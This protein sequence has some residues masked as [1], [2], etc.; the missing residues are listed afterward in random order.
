MLPCVLAL[1]FSGRADTSSVNIIKATRTKDWSLD[2]GRFSQRCIEINQNHREMY[3]EDEHLEYSLLLA[4]RVS[5]NQ[6]KVI[7]SPYDEKPIR[8]RV[9]C[10]ATMTRS[11]LFD[12][13]DTEK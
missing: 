5:R 8:K 9:K 13:F 10:S 3:E 1:I 6:K 7:S 4:H 12:L 11:N 2:Y